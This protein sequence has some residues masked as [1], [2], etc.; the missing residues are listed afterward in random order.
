MSKSG[1]RVR[2][3]QAHGS[4]PY[5]VSDQSL[6]RREKG[7]CGR[8]SS[9][10]RAINHHSSVIILRTSLPLCTLR[11]RNLAKESQ[12][13]RSNSVKNKE[14]ERRNFFRKISSSLHDRANGQRLVNSWSL[15]LGA[16]DALSYIMVTTDALVTA[17]E[18]SSCSKDSRNKELFR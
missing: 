8:V 2:G 13:G 10:L 17:I 6:E 7:A 15:L 14:I 3:P 5:E 11:L 12:R 4:Q 16:N 18:G 9:S 1:G